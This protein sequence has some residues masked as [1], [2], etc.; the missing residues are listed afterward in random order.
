METIEEWVKAIRFDQ[1]HVISQPA[2]LQ[3]IGQGRSAAVFKLP[4]AAQ[5]IK[6]FYPGYEYLAMKEADVY[7]RLAHH[8]AYPELREAGDG[9]LVLEYLDGTTFY[10]CLRTGIPITPRMVSMVD[11][12][13][14]YARSKGL[15]P[16]DIHL[17]NI[18]FTTDQTVKVIDVVRFTQHKNCPHW[19]DLKKAYFAYYQR[20]FFPKR[21]PKLIMELVIRLY[22][23]RLLQQKTG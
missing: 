19:S 17:K 4:D 3:L 5:A 9:Y 8:H 7:Q 20:R 2:E 11:E 13:L 22:R 16:S 12:A 21:Y 23:K 1:T 10:D 14:E 6:V 15:N 18:I